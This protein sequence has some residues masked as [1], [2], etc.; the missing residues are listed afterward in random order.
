MQKCRICG[1]TDFYKEAGYYFCQTCQTQNEDI[2]E[3]VLE[4]RVDSTT[5]LRKTR[6]KQLKSDIS[7]EE[8]GWTSWELYNFVLI[9]LTDELIELGVPADIKLTI[10]QLWATYLGKIEVAFIST[11]KRSL[12]KLA[13][14]YKK[15]DAEII[16]GKVQS[17]KMYKKRK[18]SGS[19]TNTS[20]ISGGPSEGSSSMRE[21]NKHK[22]LLAT[23]DYDRYLQSQAS[24]DGL[25]VFSQSAYS[26]Q[27]SSVKSSDK[28]GKIHFSSHAKEEAR[29]IKRLSKNIR[30]SERV[31]YRAKHITTQY[32]IGPHLITPMRLW[33]IIYLA[34]RIHNQPIQLGD[35]LRYG[36]E[37]HLSYYK[38][39][40]LLPPE[41]TLTTKER[42]FLNQNIEITHKG[43]R[44]IIGS[45]AKFLGVWDIVCPD[46]SS[47]VSRYCQELGLPRGIQLYA[48]RLIALSPPKMLFGKRKSY[49]P[50][51][52]GRAIAFIIVVLKI[53]LALDDI[54][55]YHISRIA[56][57]INSIAI[58]RGLLNEKLFSFREWQRYIE[59]RKTI[60]VNA[61]FPTKIKYSPSSCR[62][63][64]L[65]L[66]FVE[67]ITS[68]SNRKETDIKSSKHCLPEELINAMAKHISSINT[69]E[70][71][72]QAIDI[73]PASLTP[74]YSYLQYLLDHPLYDIP[75]IAQS[76]FALTKV[77]YLTRPDSLIELAMKCDIELEIIDHSVHFLEKMVPPFEQP[78][79]PSVDELKQL[80]DVQ[81][82][83]K[84]KQEV[85]SESLNDYLH[86]KVPCAIMLDVDKKQYYDS[87][88]SAIEGIRNI[89]LGNDFTFTETLPNGKL[90]IPCD[91]DSSDSE[92][93]ETNPNLTNAM[94]P[95]AVLLKKKFC[96]KYNLHLSL[97]EKESIR[98][99]SAMEKMRSKKLKVRSG[100]NSKGQFIK[101]SNLPIKIEQSDD[102]PFAAGENAN[103]YG[104][105]QTNVNEKRNEVESAAN[106]QVFLNN[107]MPE[108]INLSNINI[109]FD[110]L[111]LNGGLFNISDYFN[112]SDIS[113]FNENND[114]AD[115]AAS[116][117]K[118]V[119][120]QKHRFFRPF[121]EYWMYH[122]IFSRV[123]Q[124][125]FAVFEKA[126][127]RSF[128]WLLN[129]CALIVEMSTEDLYEEVCLIESYHSHTIKSFTGKTDAP[130]D[131]D[132]ISKNHWNFILNKW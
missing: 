44:R 114:I 47:L 131:V 97:A 70:L 111:D 45:M 91:S 87:I 26:V 117:T 72:T 28:E 15:R 79:M 6:I 16:Y 34:L 4:L 88:E 23:A 10:L 113:F 13:R 60:L 46:L 108:D 106:E 30:R 39:D 61:H 27:S 55:E 130:N 95:E 68:K 57:K 102:E 92:A 83:S 42:S 66:K 123:K 104:S 103:F 110:G 50:N 48:K 109:D 64:D 84:G 29:K 75:S 65:Y 127:P 122:C 107:Y 73:F 59:C 67:F 63:D 7:G 96:D 74:L 118:D 77:G 119:D 51:Y 124:K 120:K 85:A 76:D 89:N 20:V 5:K 36:R 132:S 121:K 99:S 22:R 94:D 49:I 93:E 86:A 18:R 115:I 98:N 112:F 62:I 33:A 71:T 35:M 69:N 78:R 58:D 40:K 90:A 80:I 41:I 43:M 56:E 129:E 2:R 116:K 126:L 24:S 9:G 125:N 3:E 25:S 37:G 8:L 101:G 52:E 81:D 12:P 54:T 32:K 21:L 17:Q 82:D 100:R 31:H 11:K 53:L 38:L 19:S 14:R 1:S 105:I 128:R